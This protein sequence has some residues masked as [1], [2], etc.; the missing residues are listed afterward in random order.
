MD[1]VTTSR[2][3]ET[4]DVTTSQTKVPSCCGQ[5][6]TI[7][8]DLGKFIEACCEICKDSIYVKKQDISKPQMIDD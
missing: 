8:T 4:I 3:D 1:A 7:R 6:M 5:Q 2:R